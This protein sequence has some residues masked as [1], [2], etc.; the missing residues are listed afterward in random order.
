MSE[1]R[2]VLELFEKQKDYMD[3]RVAEGIEKYRKGDIKITLTDKEGNPLSAA[4]VKVGQKS[5]EFRF[6]ANL[7]LLDELETDEKNRK[8]KE[9]SYGET[10][11]IKNSPSPHRKKVPRSH[12]TT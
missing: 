7:F 11:F 6:G 10:T 3:K 5:H 8:Y 9:A 12:C 4:R 2:K 1:R